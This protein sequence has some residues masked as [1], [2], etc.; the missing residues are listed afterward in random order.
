MVA[1]LDLAATCTKDEAWDACESNAH[2]DKAGVIAEVWT[3]VVKELG[4]EVEVDKNQ[5]WPEVR[6]RVLVKVIDDLPF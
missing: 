4:Y 2:P 1:A 5:D 6:T 3:E